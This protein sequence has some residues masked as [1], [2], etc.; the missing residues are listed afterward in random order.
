MV[1]C[2]AGFP[3]SRAYTNQSRAGL[4]SN[5]GGSLLHRSTASSTIKGWL[6]SAVQGGQTRSNQKGRRVV[7][8]DVGERELGCIQW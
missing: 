2:H 8:M 6:R 3:S 5:R 4:G 7:W 1:F